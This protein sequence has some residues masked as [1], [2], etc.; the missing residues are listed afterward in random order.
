[1]AGLDLFF[2]PELFAREWPKLLRAQA[3][4]AYRQPQRPDSDEGELRRRVENL[5]QAAAITEGSLRTNAGVGQ[6]FESRVQ[7]PRANALIFENR[8]V[9]A[10]IL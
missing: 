1:M 7:G 6:L 2:N 5:L 4:D 3:L 9:H 10:A 8:V